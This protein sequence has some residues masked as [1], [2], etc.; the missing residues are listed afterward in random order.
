MHLRTVMSQSSAS[1]INGNKSANNVEDDPDEFG[2]LDPSYREK[3]VTNFQFVQVTCWTTLI[4]MILERIRTTGSVIIKVPV[5]LALAYL[6]L[7]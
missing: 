2:S 4:C 3:V 6:D 1:G 5:S 7:F